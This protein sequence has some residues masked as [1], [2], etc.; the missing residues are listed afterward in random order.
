MEPAAIIRTTWIAIA[1]IF[2][3]Y[4]ALTIAYTLQYYS[5]NSV[6]VYTNDWIEALACDLE[7]SKMVITYPKPDAISLFM[8]RSAIRMMARV[9]PELFPMHEI[10]RS[11]VRK[12][13][14]DPLQDVQHSKPVFREDWWV[15]VDD[16]AP[17][18]VTETPTPTYPNSPS[19][20]EPIKSPKSDNVKVIRVDA[21]ATS[22]AQQP[23]TS[24]KPVRKFAKVQ[25]VPEMKRYKSPTIQHWERMDMIESILGGIATCVVQM[26]ALMAFLISIPFIFPV[27]P[28]Q[29]HSMAKVL[30]NLSPGQQR[31]SAR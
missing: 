7:A 10:A 17:L 2:G 18:S 14:Y 6:K 9:E 21:T 19:T 27:S 15:E 5:M 8:A 3:L 29:C 26:F 16:I 22:P 1:S 23:S 25:A 28:V 24:P 20:L 11:S 13:N 4:H 30:T 31:R 12:G